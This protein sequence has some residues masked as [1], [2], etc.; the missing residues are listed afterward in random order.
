MGLHARP[1]ATFVKHAAKFPCLVEVIKDG[2]TIN[3][4]SIL[5]VM[6]LAAEKGST[7][8]IRTSGKEEEEALTNLAR[9]LENMTDEELKKQK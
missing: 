6:S 2:L 7:I 5:G 3:G 9:L 4:K 8:T 1:S